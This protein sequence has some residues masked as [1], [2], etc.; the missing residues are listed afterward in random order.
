MYSLTLIF[1]I[2]SSGKR[3]SRIDQSRLEYL[4]AQ[5]NKEM[6]AESL[7]IEYESAL[8]GFFSARD[9]YN[10]QK[11]NRDLARRIYLKS[12]TRYREGLGSSLDLNQTQRQYFEAEAA[13]FSALISLVTAKSQ[14][15]NL[16]AN[17]SI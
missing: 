12:L 3:L 11:E 13:Y 16:L 17:N 6:A 14:L 15:D 8:S 2:W 4:K 1:P 9:I 7:R 10:L 5:T